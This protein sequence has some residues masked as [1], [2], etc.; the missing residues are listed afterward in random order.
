MV[1]KENVLCRYCVL[2]P[3]GYLS[4]YLDLSQS[5]SL[6][7]FE[8]LLRSMIVFFSLDQFKMNSESFGKMHCPV[9]LFVEVSVDIIWP[10]M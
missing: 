10:E 9:N 2:L 1:E 4:G 3:F 5:F 8:K 6:I 7:V